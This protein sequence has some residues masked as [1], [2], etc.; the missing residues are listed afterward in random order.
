MLQKL[1]EPIFAVASTLKC[2]LNVIKKIQMY[3]VIMCVFS[4]YFM[5]VKLTLDRKHF[6]L[7]FYFYP[8]LPVL[9]VEQKNSKTNKQTRCREKTCT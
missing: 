2:K 7:P 8:P 4:T 9:D 5:V 1:G 3:P 6:T